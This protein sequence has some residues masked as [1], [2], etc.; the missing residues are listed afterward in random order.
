MDPKWIKFIKNGL[1]LI[2]NGLKMDG[3]W[4]QIENADTFM[5]MDEHPGSTVDRLQLAPGRISN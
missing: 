5:T 1:K 3:K 4:M 2:E